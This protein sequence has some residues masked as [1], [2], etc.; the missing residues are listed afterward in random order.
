MDR[1]DEEGGKLLHSTGG[2]IQ[3]EPNPWFLNVQE[4]H[5]FAHVQLYKFCVLLHMFQ[6]M[7]YNLYTFAHVPL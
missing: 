6:S 1:E 4:C 5:S 2:I 7:L 3:T